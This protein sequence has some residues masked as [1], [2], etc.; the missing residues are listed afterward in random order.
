[1]V[2]RFPVVPAQIEAGPETVGIGKGLTRT[3]NS[4]GV[5]PLHPVEGLV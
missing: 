1:V 3:L 5:S 4:V 2:Y